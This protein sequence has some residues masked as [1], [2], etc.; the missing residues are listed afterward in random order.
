V[1]AV[2]IVVAAIVLSSLAIVQPGETRAVRFFGSYVGPV[3]RT[4]LLWVLPLA[5]S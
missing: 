4:G 3:R 2:P 1:P 5:Y